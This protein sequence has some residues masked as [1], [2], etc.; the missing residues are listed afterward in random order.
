[1]KSLHNIEKSAFRQGEYVGYANGVW[2]I[3]KQGMQWYAY[4][5]REGNSMYAETLS[6][7]SEKLTA[8]E[9]AGL[10]VLV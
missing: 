4:R 3:T 6:E 8:Y 10:M 7:M 2:R 9:N 5:M 1:M